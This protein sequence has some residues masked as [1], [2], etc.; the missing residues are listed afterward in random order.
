[1]GESRK[2]DVVINSVK[3]S[4][5]IEQYKGGDFAFIRSKKKVVL[6]PEKSSFGRVVFPVS[7]LKRRKGRKGL[8]MVGETGVNDTFNDFRDKV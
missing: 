1:M 3:G 5:E 8:Q 7:R 6:N 4:R 2:Q